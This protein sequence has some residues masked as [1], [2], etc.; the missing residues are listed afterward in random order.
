M[1]YLDSCALVK[2]ISPAPETG[3]LERYLRTHAKVRHVASALVRTEVRRALTRIGAPARLQHT[4][5]RLLAAVI[6]IAITDEL[7]DAAGRL[8]EPGLRSLDAIH[9]A[10]A[11]SLG[12]G[13]TAF[14]TYDKRL[15][16]AAKAEGLPTAAP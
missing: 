6:T 15:L 4:A 12:R 16:A 3:P 1:I 11:Q 14:V 2:L 5:D 10:T 9:L 7:L 8:P 13:L